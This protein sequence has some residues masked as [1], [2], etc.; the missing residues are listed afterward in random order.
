MKKSFL[1][2]RKVRELI[3]LKKYNEAEKVLKE[4]I[5]D[6]PDDEY[7]C[8]ALFDIHLKKGNYDKADKILDKILQKNPENYFFL[9]R[10]GDLLVATN[11]HK[12]AL[13]IFNNLYHSK[14]DPH[15]SWRLANEYYRLK[16]FDKADYFF[17]QTIPK[18]YDNPELNFLGFLINKAL[19]K[20]DKAHDLIDSAINYS[21][22]P[23]QY[24]SRKMQFQT[25]LKGISA[26]QWEKSLKYSTSKN[27]PFVLKELAEKFLKENKFEK[28]EIYYKEILKAD[29]NDYNKSRLGYVYYKWKKYDLALSIFLEMPLKSFLIPSF[30]A[31]V[32]KSARV[33][34]QEQKVIEHLQDL[35][36]KN[37]EAKQ[38]WGAIKR[39]S[40]T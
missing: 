23:E 17:N 16:Q 20:Y 27:E 32:I 31:M 3:R 6:Y 22:K 40:T 5:K 12:Q 33:T 4:L 29:A 34:G 24:I 9:S 2:L 1:D 11:K 14:K 28:A 18:L 38:L 21:H 37:P 13:K 15:V 30:I 7:A 8:G 19:K 39:L 10:K 36:E 26:L 25:E 35:L